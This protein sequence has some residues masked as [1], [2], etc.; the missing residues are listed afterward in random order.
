MSVD[1]DLLGG[2]YATVLDV[3][4]FRGDFAR[5]ALKTWPDTRVL[6]FEPLEPKPED[7]DTEQWTWFP[8]AIGEADARVTINRN[9][10]VPSSSIL[11]MANLH[12]SAFPYT[13]R[14]TEAEV[15]MLPLDQ[16]VAIVKAP[17]L[18]KIDVQGYELHVLKGAA[19]QVLKLCTAVVLEVS[20]EPL[21]HGAPTPAQL[22]TLLGANGFEHMSRVDDLY[23]PRAP[24]LLLQSDEL[25]VRP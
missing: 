2:P 10:F 1:T 5:A 7:A 21:Y 4:A 19:Q 16:F 25:W 17:A 8:T 18:L 6:S 24:K 22:A 20:W 14:V 13:K 3:G 23:H 9:E 12:R 11:P 15:G